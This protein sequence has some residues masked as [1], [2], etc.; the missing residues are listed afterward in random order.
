MNQELL[1][2]ILR[3]DPETGDFF[4][5]VSRSNRIKVG[6]KAGSTNKMGYRIIYC[7]TRLQYAHR[8]AWL[9][10]YGYWPDQ[11]DH[12]NGNTSDNRI[13]NLRVA[14]QSQNNANRVG[15]NNKKGATFDRRREKWIAYI[16][17]DGKTRYL[18]GFDTEEEAHIAYCDAAKHLFGDFA[19]L[20]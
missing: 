17:K 5:R 16:K 7:G 14:T 9:Y 2:Q 3:Y 19:R 18:G 1:R 6:M 8:L 11:I 13:S 20:E 15:K 4:W 10:V 12:I